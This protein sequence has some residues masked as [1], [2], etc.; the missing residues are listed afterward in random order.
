M[1]NVLLNF[2]VILE[3]RSDGVARMLAE[4]SLSWKI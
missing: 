4:C 1:K 3:L 2:F